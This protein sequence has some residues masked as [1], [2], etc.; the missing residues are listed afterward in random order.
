MGGG[1]CKCSPG[2]RGGV[3]VLRAW[4]PD[5]DRLRQTL[6]GPRPSCVTLCSN[7]TL[8]PSPL[9]SAKRLLSPQLPRGVG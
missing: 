8:S 1:Q 7:A 3:G 5:P 4:A 2:R 6:L 9:S